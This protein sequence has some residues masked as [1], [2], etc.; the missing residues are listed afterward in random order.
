MPQQPSLQ[1]DGPPR[2]KN[3]MV[4]PLFG[5][6]HVRCTPRPDGSLLLVNTEPLGAYPRCI[7]EYLLHWAEH[8]PERAFLLE[9]RAG[10]GWGGVT[11]SEALLEVERIAGALL[12]MRIAP[13]QPIA[14]LSDN[15]VE[16]GLLSLAAQHVG[17]PVAPISPAYSLISSDFQKLKSII[18]RLQPALIYVDNFERFLPALDAVR[19]SHDAVIVSG[20]SGPRPAAA[21]R[22]F[23]ELDS[24]DTHSV[25]RAF[26]AVTADGVAKVLFT[27]GSTDE[28]KGVL[29]TQR[30]LCANQQQKAQMWPFLETEP[31]VLV[32]WLPWNHT[33][34][35]NHNFNLVLRNGGTLY[36]DEGR[37]TAAQFA[38]TLA[39]LAEVAP[40]IY[41]N[42]P[43]GF[44]MLIPALLKQEELR[45]RF[46]SRL[47][48]IFY[49]AAALPKHLWDALEELST[50]NAGGRI[51]LLSAWGSTETAPLATDGCARASGPGVI[52]IPVPGC[53][54]KLLPNGE[55][56]EVRVRGPNVF[57]GYWGRPDLTARSFDEEGFY[58]IG[59][60]VRF[61]DE[62]QPERGLL[63]DGR[64]AE[65]F[66]LTTGTWVSVGLLRLRAI[67]AMAPI[68]QDIVVAGHDRS[69]V[70]LLVFPNVAACR[71]LAP[72]LVYDAPVSQVLAHPRIRQLA[73][74]GLEA[75]R[76]A[77]PASSAHAA[78]ALLMAEGASIDAGEITDKGYINQRIVLSR[79]CDLVE[80]VF[81]EDT[82]AFIA[83]SK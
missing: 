17:I 69:D 3:T 46:F 81:A 78:G 43:R 20:G 62:A 57:T 30:M 26:A 33:F 34:G 52:G 19:N 6:G 73:A 53:D 70:R 60:A 56:L 21:V 68:A 9:R 11:Y 48:V 18:G 47:E 23:A 14:I 29:I 82:S 38:A 7:T 55:K 50:A 24:A 37:P 31:P 83:P 8:A 49:A 65:D 32:D 28:P 5:P 41:F 67:S 77:F 61:V 45:D 76:L 71:E 10:G 25:R 22:R 2:E 42:V 36:V 59:D 72:E 39:N 1:F 63:F 35:G 13:E 80:A 16:H 40:T 54:L 51:P 15:S 74:A 58:Q 4:D 27:S 12:A 79:R 75:L 66:K 44:E 64:V